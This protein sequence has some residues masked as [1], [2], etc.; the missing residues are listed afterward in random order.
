M[1]FLSA[2]HVEIRPRNIHAPALSQTE[3]RPVARESAV[4]AYLETLALGCVL[5][6][7]AGV[8]P[9]VMYLHG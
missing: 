5:A 6:G 3:G 7:V 1:T 2:S 8:L 4:A 9:L